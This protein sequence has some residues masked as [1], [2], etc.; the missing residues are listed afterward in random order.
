MKS[1]YHAKFLFRYISSLK[2]LS[3]FECTFSY[4]CLNSLPD[5]LLSLKMSNM[6]FEASDFHE[7]RLPNELRVLCVNETLECCNVLSNIVNHNQLIE[8]SNVD[9]SLDVPDSRDDIYFLDTRIAEE[10]KARIGYIIAE[11]GKFLN[12]LP[13]L[14][15]LRL[16]F[17]SYIGKEVIDHFFVRDAFDSLTGFSFAG[18]ACPFSYLP[19]SCLRLKL[20]NY[21][22]LKR[23]FPE[24]LNT[25][26]IDL[27]HF[28]KSFEYFWDQFI[29]PLNNLYCLKIRSIGSITKDTE[30]I[31]FS[32][33]QFPDRLHT[34]ELEK[35]DGR[36]CKFIFNELPP[37][38]IYVSVSCMES[39]ENAVVFHV[40]SVDDESLKSK[41]V[42]HS[43]EDNLQP[44]DIPN[45][46]NSI[47][48]FPED[49]E[50]DEVQRK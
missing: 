27:S 4:E 10:R 13:V 50:V 18:V 23:P 19:P 33:L 49:E 12:E 44:E 29:T 1:I 36:G 42:F 25:L 24:T 15:S 39:T 38:M 32:F 28:T 34:L 5:T 8:L 7:I 48:Q 43:N 22:F 47:I 2:E 14:K 30:T 41:F 31:D 26:E 6:R 40:E 37:S 20:E 16:E 3:L 46:P 45:S 9:I 35:T 17:L 11:L 21:T